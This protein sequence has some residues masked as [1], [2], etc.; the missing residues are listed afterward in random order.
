M[1]PIKS[2]GVRRNSLVHSVTHAL[3]HGDLNV[4]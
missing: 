1:N 2:T 3:A 4:G